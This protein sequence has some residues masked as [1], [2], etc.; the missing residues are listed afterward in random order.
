MPGHR[1]T[2]E[3]DIQLRKMLDAGLEA[4][5]IAFRLGRK[6]RT[7]VYSRVQR[8]ARKPASNKIAGGRLATATM[9]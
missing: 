5:L 3:E 1:W 6:R 7:D 2:P 9:D 8:L 4:E